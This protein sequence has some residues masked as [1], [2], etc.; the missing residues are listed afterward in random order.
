M[1][2]M[3][4][5]RWTQ[6]IAGDAS[7]RGVLRGI[8]AA[9]VALAIGARGAEAVTCIK[10]GKECDPKK[11]GQCCSGNCRKKARGHTCKPAPGA[12]GCTVN[13]DFCEATTDVVRCPG[14]PNGLCVVLDNG[15]PFCSL[16][17]ICTACETGA[18]CDATG[19]EGG[20]CVTRCPRCVRTGGSACVFPIASV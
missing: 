18:D 16:G 14:D 15:K 6:R 7:R 10:N 9:A 13:G 3:R 12:F 19:T 8:G 2:G 5:D 11:R 4:F 17:T 1:D 20:I